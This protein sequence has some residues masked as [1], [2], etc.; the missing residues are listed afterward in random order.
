MVLYFKQVFFFILEIIPKVK[1][2]DFRR[3]S[4]GVTK[5]MYEE[6]DDIELLCELG[7]LS[8][9]KQIATCQPCRHLLRFCISILINRWD[10][11]RY[12]NFFDAVKV[13]RNSKNLFATS[14]VL[15]HWVD[16][17]KKAEKL[18]KIAKTTKEPMKAINKYR[19]IFEE[20]IK[21]NSIIK[22]HIRSLV[23]NTNPI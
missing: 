11:F 4:F 21:I 23:V 20:S 18:M 3:N 12:I 6:L 17:K 19:Y 22:E 14:I 15:D 1:K 8:N 7:V 13:I 9:R 5:W 2:L 16:N 10:E